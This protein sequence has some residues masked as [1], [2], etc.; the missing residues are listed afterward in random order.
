MEFYAHSAEGKGK[1]DW[2]KLKD[3][4]S[5]AAE[6]SRDFSARFG[7]GE[8]GYAA[9]IL[10]DIGK[11]SDEFQSKLDGKNIR[12]DHSTA[13]AKEAMARYGEGIGKILAYIIAGHHAGLA[14][15]IGDGDDSALYSRLNNTLI[16]KYDNFRDELQK[17]IEIQPALPKLNSQ[18]D[19]LSFSVFMLIRMIYSC[20]V[21]ADFLD[22]EKF[23]DEIK[24][25]K[26]EQKTTV[27]EL[28]KRLIFCLSEI[29]GKAERTEL[30]KHRNKIMQLCLEKAELKP[31]FFTLTVPTGGGKTYSSLAFALKH[32]KLHNL[33]RVI[34]VIPYT[35]II[36][37][38]AEVFNKALGIENV[39]EHHSNYDYKD[40]SDD[41]SENDYKMR[42]A[43]E[44]WNMPV[45]AT[46]NVQFFES[47]F[48]NRSSR[49][50]K[51]HN[52]SKSVIILDEAQM[53]PVEYMKPAVY[54]PVS[55]TH[56]TLPTK[57][58]V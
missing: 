35:S 33:D 4:L 14:D 55:Y 57:R 40:E 34:Y 7:A 54:A 8:L 42:L 32:A 16:A 53:L 52:I 1:E 3:H 26:R 41:L 5:A 30:N 45:I 37:Q 9:G 10:H 20:V 24:N 50:R 21:D 23:Y 44:N 13:G 51:L 15:Y 46:T 28:E 58:I 25:K 19:E 43:S 47:L 29:S 39:L 48:K 22:T 2:Q 12:V 6:M 18:K 56:L 27:E 11:Y 49:C 36:E 31:G 38:N 17:E